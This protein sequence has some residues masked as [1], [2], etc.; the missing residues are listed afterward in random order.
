MKFKYQ[1]KNQEG[2]LQAGFVEAADREGAATI[3]TSH[4][5][6]VLLLEEVGRPGVFDRLGGYFSR[7]KQ[8]D[9]MIFTR[10]LATLLDARLPLPNALQT[11]YAQTNQPVLKEAIK[12]VAD[13]VASGLT[14]S[15]ALDRQQGVFSNFYV[16]MIRSAEVVGNMDEAAVFLA[17]YLEKE[18]SITSKA[19]SAL[20]YPAIIIALFSV[21]AVVMITV[22]FPQI[23]P[24]FA[25]SGVQLPWYTKALLGIGDFL[26]QW[27][28]I[29]IFVFF[30][31]MLLVA[32]YFQTPEGKALWDDMKV[33]LPIMDKVYVP[34]TMTRLATVMSML[35][36]GGVPVTQAVE[37]AGQTVNNALYQDLMAGVAEDV[38]QGQPL[39]ASLAKYPEYFPPL[40]SQ[41]LVVGEATG[42]VDKMLERVGVFYGRE[43]DSVVSN[44]VDLIQPVLMVFIGGL[45][46][47]LFAS[48]LIP[49]Y[50]MT[51]TV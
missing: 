8:V 28:L 12:M 29:L 41:M 13:D 5:L 50:Q 46:G 17:D 42:R 11:L 39:S 7:V 48:I 31:F 6:F 18:N 32:N 15:Q 24:I 2:E 43:V 14:F 47:L 23:G 40:V 1:A 35:L 3:L 49:M 38:R 9:V 33:R 10:Q 25:E 45:V 30:V 19:R 21:V 44:L 20:I 37:I 22:V 16:S 36:K 26:G 51:S 4:G 34:L 27:W